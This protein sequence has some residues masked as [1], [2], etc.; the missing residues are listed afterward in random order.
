MKYYCSFTSGSCGNSGVYVDGRTR[1]LVDAGTNTKYISSC[2]RELMLTAGDLTHIAITHAHSDHISALPVL[3]KNCAA[4]VVCS[5][6]T[7]YQLPVKPDKVM[8]FTPGEMLSLGD[9]IVGTA[10]TPHDCDGSCCYS[11]GEGRGRI[12]VCTDIGHMTAGIFDMLKSCGTVCIE[13]NHDVQMLKTGPYPY[14]LKKRVLSDVG[15]L[16]N[17]DCAKAVARL[18]ENGVSHFL[19]SH[20]SETNNTPGTALRESRGALSGAGA[21]NEVEV[22]VAGARLMQAPI[23]L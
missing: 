12:S 5:E 19:L 14:Y 13:S 15:H 9:V 21:L 4:T 18:A 11:F 8:L 3:L 1:I 7:Y 20:L 2:L 10:P 16:S 17:E 22:T 23:M 6:D